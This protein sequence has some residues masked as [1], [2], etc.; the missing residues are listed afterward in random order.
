MI[1]AASSNFGIPYLLEWVAIVLFVAFVW[2]YIVPPLRRAM[3][4]QTETI[5]EQLSSGERVREEAQQLL[6][7]RRTALERARKEAESIAAQAQRNA[8]ALLEQGRQRAEQEY[9]HALVRAG[10]AI[11]LARTQ[12]REEILEEIGAAIVGAAARLVAAELDEPIHR[13]LIAEAI[14]AAESEQAI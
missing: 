1:V 3:N 5:R 9:E 13:R 10:S 14:A 2:R 6:A 4:K 8:E 12:I 11:E 7:A